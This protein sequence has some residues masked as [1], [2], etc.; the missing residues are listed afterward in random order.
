M[1]ESCEFVENFFCESE[2]ERGNTEKVEAGN[3]GSCDCGLVEMK[4]KEI[5]VNPRQLYHYPMIHIAQQR[6]IDATH[7]EIVKEFCFATK[8]EETAKH[9]SQR[10]QQR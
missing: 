7:N 5:V 10:N 4:Y 3:C 2:H 6:V 1:M 9:N 8:T